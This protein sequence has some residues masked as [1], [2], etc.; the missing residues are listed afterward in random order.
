MKNVRGFTLVELSI[1]L[2][3]I[4]LIV[5]GILVGRDLI[6]AAQMRQVQTSYE[7][8][9]AAVNTFRSKYNCIPG[10]CPNATDFFG[11]SINGTFNGGVGCPP[12]LAPGTV[13]LHWNN[14]PDTATCNGNGDG[15]IDGSETI[16][17]EF[18]L[19]QQLASAGLITGTYTGGLTGGGYPS[20][21]TVGINIPTVTGLGAGYGWLAVDGD[22]W[23]MLADSSSPATMGLLP[24]P[25][26]TVLIAIGETGRASFTPVLMQSFDT[27]F[28]DGSPT[29]GRI[30]EV[31]NMFG[32]AHCTNA[33]QPTATDS[34]N[35]GAQYKT[36]DTVFKDQYNCVLMYTHWL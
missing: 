26:G 3:I 35:E 2:V 27:K 12:D 20:Q 21:I 23:E 10:D 22:N 34:T 5:G 24:G 11:T 4:G 29:T 16:F 8:M 18:T 15:L 6:E 1:V 31:G 13:W 30:Q 33:A 9:T 14:I 25:I 7:E 36:S 32:S 17:E 28:D 19:W